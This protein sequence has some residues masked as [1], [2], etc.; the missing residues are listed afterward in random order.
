MTIP[1]GIV[2]SRPGASG[3]QFV[4]GQSFTMISSNGGDNVAV[5]SGDVIV[6]VTQGNGSSFTVS[7]GSLTWRQWGE[8]FWTATASSTTTVT[9]SV[10]KG[11]SA[12]NARVHILVFRGAA[13]V[14]GEAN[15]ASANS[16]IQF[17]TEQFVDNSVLV[18]AIGSAKDMSTRTWYTTS[19]G[20]VIERD[21]YSDSGWN[22]L[23]G[24]YSSGGTRGTKTVG[25]S[26]PTLGAGGSANAWM[27]EVRRSDTAEPAATTESFPTG[28]GNNPR[29]IGRAIKIGSD[30]ATAISVTQSD[31]VGTAPASGH[32]LY[33]IVYAAGG[34]L[35]DAPTGWK[36]W[37]KYNDYFFFSKIAGAS[38]GTY[39]WGAS[40]G[41]SDKSIAHVFV[42][43]K[44][45][46]FEVG[47]VTFPYDSNLQSWTPTGF[48]GNDGMEIATQLMLSAS[49]KYSQ[50]LGSRT[51][52][53]YSLDMS[54]AR[55]KRGAAQNSSVS[56]IKPYVRSIPSS[57]GSFSGGSVTGTGNTNPWSDTFFFNRTVRS[58]PSTSPSVRSAAIANNG[59]S[60]T[61]VTFSMLS[62]TYSLGDLLI[63]TLQGGV[64]FKSGSAPT[65]SPSGW[66]AISNTSGR[67][68]AKIAAAVEADISATGG[69]GLP[70]NWWTIS[71]VALNPNGLTLSIPGS[72]KAG[73][74]S[75]GNNMSS[76]PVYKNNARWIGFLRANRTGSNPYDVT[77]TFS[78]QGLSTFTDHA[79]YTPTNRIDVVKS[80]TMS[81]EGQAG[82]ATY[83][84]VT[85]PHSFFFDGTYELYAWVSQA[86]L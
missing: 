27:L 56:E 29:V 53:N 26:T 23:T 62:L 44:A 19:A 33:A 34:N 31:F 14:G 84:G 67:M 49:L 76:T 8:N 57:Q 10:T 25:L 77:T 1:I 60:T 65:F 73:L 50:P 36:L 15:T 38:E 68:Y 2:S 48:G 5:Q 4:S 22:R 63:A 86:G 71:V 69:S 58:Q 28:Y 35:N 6:V 43:D 61:T 54:S 32:L 82:P 18:T 45:T 80:A 74:I 42:I 81:T 46:E 72:I 47:L 41:L 17:P 39:T 21:Y 59:S 51:G 11:G 9:V 40:A 55:H 16:P 75:W 3:P 13:V 52:Q 79:T 37:D 30:S 20:T 12:T 85:T 24:H 7:G 83:S 70:A 78:D 66:T 64:D